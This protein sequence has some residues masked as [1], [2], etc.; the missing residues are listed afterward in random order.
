MQLLW[1]KLNI[2]LISWCYTCKPDG[3]S[4]DHLLIHSSLARELWDTILVLFGVQWVT[5]RRVMDLLAV[6]K[7]NWDDIGI[8]RFGKSFLIV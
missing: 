3:E 7:E 6:G 1:G 4:V 5:P 8:M 2:I